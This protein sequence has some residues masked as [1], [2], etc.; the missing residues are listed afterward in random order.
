MHPYP[1]RI[2]SLAAEGPEILHLV[3]ALD[4]LVGATSFARRPRQVRTIP[5]VGGFS[6]PDLEKALALKPDLVIT[7]SDIQAEAAAYF[8]RR[9]VPVL[10]LNA[11]TLE[12]VW[13]NILLVGAAVGR[14]REAEAGVRR[15][16]QRLARIREKA[17]IRRRVRVFFEEWPDPLIAGIGWVSDLIQHLGGE[18]VFRELARLPRANERIVSCEEVVRRR[19]EVI[20]ASWCGRK[21]NLEAIRTRPGWRDVPAVRCGRVHAIPSEIILQPGPSLVRGAARLARILKDA[22]SAPVEPVP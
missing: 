5:K 20:V 16:K 2:V 6:T 12:G 14:Q 13:R 22:A 17:G 9:G 8:A 10:A 21:V 3:G 11:S 7:T 1:Q 15:L 19:P 18:D 4:R